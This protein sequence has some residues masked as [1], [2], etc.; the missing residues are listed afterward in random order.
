[1]RPHEVS[2]TDRPVPPLLDVDLLLVQSSL[3]SSLDGSSQE[4]TIWT[5][6]PWIL[7]V[8]GLLVLCEFQDFVL[9]GVIFHSLQN[10][11][12]RGPWRRELCSLF[13][14]EM[15]QI[16]FLLIKSESWFCHC[17]QT[18]FEGSES[19][20]AVTTVL[21]HMK[22][23]CVCVIYLISSD[24]SEVDGRICE[25]VT[26]NLIDLIWIWLNL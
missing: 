22:E 9:G 1:M 25:H 5:L 15:T 18:D 17:T 20:A 4:T 7:D 23:V 19:S 8:P 24:W 16:N 3:D 10:Q 2:L 12:V 21:F 14:T 26:Q 11:V 13:D 6:Q